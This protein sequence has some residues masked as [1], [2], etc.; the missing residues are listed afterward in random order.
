MEKEESYSSRFLPLS[1]PGSLSCLGFLGVDVAAKLGFL[2]QQKY[3]GIFL[4]SNGLFLTGRSR[5]SA[6]KGAFIQLC[7]GRWCD[8]HSIQAGNTHSNTHP[9]CCYFLVP[10]LRGSERGAFSLCVLCSYMEVSWLSP[11]VASAPGHSCP[12]WQLSD[13]FL[14]WLFLE[15]SVQLAAGRERLSCLV[16]GEGSEVS[17]CHFTLMAQRS[18]DLCV[19]VVR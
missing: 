3:S 6:K 19:C 8:E 14:I 5:F 13:E 15:L 10:I 9:Q 7:M 16:L 18:W 12:P 2:L 11:A 4:G 1:A 17:L